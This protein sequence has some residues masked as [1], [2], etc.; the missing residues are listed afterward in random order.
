LIFGAR[1]RIW[2]WVRYEQSGRVVGR[3][4]IIKDGRTT[5]FAAPK[6]DLERRPFAWLSDFALASGL[7]TLAYL[8]SW[9]G[10]GLWIAEQLHR[11]DSMVGCDRAGW[12]AAVGL[13]M[14]AATLA[15]DGAELRTPQ[16]ADDLPGFRQWPWP[17]PT[18]AEWAAVSP[19]QWAV[20]WAVLR[21]LV[22][23]AHGAHPALVGVRGPAAR[24]ASA[25]VRDALG[26]AVGVVRDLRTATLARELEKQHDWPRWV[27][28]SLPP[29]QALWAWLETKPDEPRWAVADCSGPEFPQFRLRDG[30][31]LIHA[32][33]EP[34]GASPEVLAKVLA[35]TL[36][37][38]L[39]RGGAAGDWGDG[40][41]EA[42]LGLQEARGA[43][44]DRLDASEALVVD[45]GCQEAAEAF[46]EL[47]AD[48]HATGSLGLVEGDQIDRRPVLR[49]VDHAAGDRLEIPKP[50]TI[51]IARRRG[52]VVPDEATSRI[53][54]E[55][56][57]L[58]SDRADAWVVSWSWWESRR[59]RSGARPLRAVGG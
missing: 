50:P 33:E 24:R 21:N 27:E 32:D 58:V 2:E 30:W 52:L 48:I 56:G 39:A 51:A 14:P 34:E 54:A 38:A 44:R 36:P 57:R 1:F 43:P 59:S 17:A 15:A 6:E 19:A 41:R 4:E 23:P 37:E 8:R 47:I 53:L 13:R 26:A 29:R 5:R 11:P 3:G 20:A 18:S 49:K 42:W 40:H 12:D 31:T 16:P 46:L 28:F 35:A 25:A 7:G 9:Q 10:R 55:A 22:A 45:Y